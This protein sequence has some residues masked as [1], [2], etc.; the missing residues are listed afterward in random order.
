MAETPVVN[1][2]EAETSADSTPVE[3]EQESNDSEVVEN[4]ETDVQRNLKI[5]L[6][7][8]RERRRA[9]EAQLKQVQYK[10]P[11][12]EDETVKRFLNVEATTLINNKLLTDPSFKD[13]VDLVQDEMLR[14]GKNI[15]DAD[16]AVI[17]RLFRD[18]TSGQTEETLSAKPPKQLKTNA[19]PEEKERISP[20]LQEELDMFDN[21]AKSFGK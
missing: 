15:E 10:A 1:Q 6:Q 5:A 13:R 14:T 11:E 19:I 4:T 20:E 12:N 3:N 17:A 2:E 7:K 9:A 16:N 8:E 21:M 18:L